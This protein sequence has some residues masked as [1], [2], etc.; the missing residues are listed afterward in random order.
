MTDFTQP[1][2]ALW[3]VLSALSLTQHDGNKYQLRDYLESSSGEKVELEEEFYYYNI[4]ITD[5]TNNRNWS[6]KFKYHNFNQ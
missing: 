6:I 5:K 3:G 2:A 4:D 1:K